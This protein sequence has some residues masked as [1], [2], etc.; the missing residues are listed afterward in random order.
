MGVTPYHYLLSRRLDAAMRRLRS[1]R[2]PVL[3]TALEC[4]FG[5][6][7]EFTRRFRRRFGTSPASYRRNAL[8]RS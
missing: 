5:D 7:S 4:G 1:T 8:G 3:T 2:E 6:L